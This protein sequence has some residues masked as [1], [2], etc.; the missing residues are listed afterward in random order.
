MW[1]DDHLMTYVEPEYVRFE[2]AR[3]EGEREGAGHKEMLVLQSSSLA[4]ERPSHIPPYM[5]DFP[6]VH[7]YKRTPV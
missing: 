3:D 7:A 2:E 5:P 6:D 4:Q 1:L